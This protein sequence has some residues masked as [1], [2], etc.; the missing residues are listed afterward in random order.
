MEFSFS[1]KGSAIPCEVVLDDDNGRY[2][3]RKA[4]HSGEF[5]NSAEQLFSWVQDNWQEKDFNDPN[6]YYHLL[7]EIKKIVEY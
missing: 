2:M 3:L 6:E 4:D 5:F 7:K 1:C